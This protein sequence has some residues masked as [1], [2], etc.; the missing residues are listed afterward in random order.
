MNISYNLQCKFQYAVIQFTPKRDIRFGIKIEYERCLDSVFM[1]F[2][3]QILQ[4][5]GNQ[6]FKRS[7]ESLKVLIRFVKVYLYRRHRRRHTK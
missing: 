5:H 7:Q 3:L 2:T 6:L 1:V 4:T